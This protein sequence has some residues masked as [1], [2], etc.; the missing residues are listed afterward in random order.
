MDSLT[1]RIYGSKKILKDSLKIYNIMQEAHWL[2]I[3]VRADEDTKYFLALDLCLVIRSELF[4]AV[5]TSL[6]ESCMPHHQQCG[7][8]LASLL[9]ANSACQLHSS[10][11]CSCSKILAVYKTSWKH[12]NNFANREIHAQQQTNLWF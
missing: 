5:C 1:S 11:T 8:R 7:I 2:T 10:I 12:M 6:L 4:K 3:G 9:L